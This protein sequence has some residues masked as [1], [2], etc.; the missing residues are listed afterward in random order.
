M[1]A[2]ALRSPYA[3]AV[4]RLRTDAGASTPALTQVL[5]VVGFAA[6]AALGAQAEFRFYL[7]EVPVTLQTLAVY[8]AGLFLGSRNG[9]L[10]MLLYVAAGLLLPIYSGGASG[11]EHL[12]GLTGGYLL[13]MP[14]AALAAGAVSRRW[15][16]PLGAVV[17][18]LAGSAALFTLGVTWLH[19]AADHATWLESID[20]GWLRFIVWDLTKVGLVAA[21][22]SGVRKL[23]A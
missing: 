13:G 22:Y 18:A 8:G 5:G 12:L 15:N 1:P 9:L 16:G 20:K 14:L 17:A 2:L 3:S 4:D 6:L 23:A 11:V 21:L 7:W 10:A 19:F